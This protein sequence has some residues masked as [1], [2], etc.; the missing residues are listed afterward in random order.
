MQPNGDLVAPRPPLAHAPG[1]LRG[2]ARRPRIL[3][4]IHALVHGGMERVVVDLVQRTAAERF[5]SHVLA[6]EMLGPLAD[7]LAPVAT[8]HRSGPLPRWTMAWPIRL[9]Q[10]IRDIAPDVVHTHGRVWYKASLAARLAHVPRVIHTDHGRGNPDPW[11][12]RRVDRV[13]ASRTDVTVAVSEA[14]ADHLRAR[15]I[16]PRRR[17]DVIANGV[18]TRSYEPRGE[19]PRVRAALQI[20]PEAPII[21]TVGRFDPIKAYDLMVEAFAILLA[22]WQRGPRPVLM[23]VGDGAERP[24]IEATAA[25]C[26]IGHAVRI[27]G[28]VNDVARYHSAMSVF[29][30]SSHS[31]GTSISLL[32]AMSSGVCPVVTDVG[33]NPA[34]LGESLSHRLV[35]PRAP[36]ALAAAWNAALTDDARRRRDAAIARDRVRQHFAL[37]RVIERYMA[38]YEPAVAAGRQPVAYGEPQHV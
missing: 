18:D 16:G 13:A 12:Q 36:A 20:A 30:L 33:G 29:S 6:M 32:E 2:R 27:T 38:L 34:C 14:L 17:I 11:L 4:I 23:F 37:D 25:R 24:L 9:A 7:E 31:E 8:V 19:D 26:G 35:P 21:G 22:G 3:H 1:Q 5:E 28:L 10:Q 15:V